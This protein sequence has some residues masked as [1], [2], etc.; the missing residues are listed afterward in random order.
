MVCIRFI[1]LA[2]SLGVETICEIEI[3]LFL[4]FQFGWM[5]FSFSLLMAIASFDTCFAMFT[6]D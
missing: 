4:V 3:L 5:C 2:F 1:F 6:L